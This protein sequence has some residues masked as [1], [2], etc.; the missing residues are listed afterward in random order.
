MKKKIFAVSLLIIALMSCLVL[1]ASAFSGIDDAQANTVPGSRYLNV[2]GWDTMFC[3]SRSYRQF[4]SNPAFDLV[5]DSSFSSSDAQI[6]YKDFLIASDPDYEENNFVIYVD[7]LSPVAGRSRVNWRLG[8]LDGSSAF[9]FNFGFTGTSP[10]RCNFASTY[11]LAAGN[12]SVFLPAGYRI[13][14]SVFFDLLVPVRSVDSSGAVSY[15]YERIQLSLSDLDTAIGSRDAWVPILP[16]LSAFTGIDTDRLSDCIIL[17][18]RWEGELS[19]PGSMLESTVYLSFVSLSDNRPVYSDPADIARF[20]STYQD[21][22]IVNNGD[23]SEADFVS[24]LGDSLSAF[25]SIRLV[26]DFSLGGI[27]AVVLC[28]GFVVALIKIFS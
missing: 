4:F 11:A 25:L 7:S 12:F 2:L 13:V 22:R 14:Y 9:S 16:A 28:L 18:S 21:I 15:D 19:K 27:L 3:D 17:N 24:W 5:A 1:P 6:Y 26:G 23:L 10:V 8:L 20:A